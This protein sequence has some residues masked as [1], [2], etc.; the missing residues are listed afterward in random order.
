MR[1]WVTKSNGLYRNPMKTI[2]N[3]FILTLEENGYFKEFEPSLAE[4]FAYVLEGEIEVRLGKRDYI[5]KAGESI[6]FRASDDHQIRNHFDGNFQILLVRIR[7]LFVKIFY[8]AIEKGELQW[9]CAKLFGLKM[10]QN[11]TMMSQY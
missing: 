10:S 4:T 7:F 5:A 3:R 1:K 9:L 8:S 6:Y 11:N 2:W